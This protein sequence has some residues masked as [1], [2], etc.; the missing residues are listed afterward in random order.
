MTRC[1]F[2]RR[3]LV[4]K[5]LFA[6]Y[7]PDPDVTGFAPH[8]LVRSLERELCFL[9]IE[10]RW[11]PLGGGVT[12]GTAC[13]ACT[14]KLPA[15]GILVAV[16][17]Q[18]GRRFEIHILQV[19]LQVQRPVT[20]GALDGTM[21]ASELEFRSRVIELAKV[22]ESSCRVAGLTSRSV[23]VYEHTH[24]GRE[25]VAVRI[26]VTS[27]ARQA[28]E[29][30]AARGGA[31]T[32]ERLMTI[33]AIGCNMRAGENKPGLL[34]TR[35]RERSHVEIVFAMALLAVV[36][37]WRSRELLLVRVLVAVGTLREFDFEYCR[38]ARWSVT[39]GAFDVRVFSAKRKSSLR[40]VFDGE[41]GLLETID[42]VTAF[43]LAAVLP[44]GK[45]PVVRVRLVA[46]CALLMS[47]VSLEIAPAV[48]GIA[49]N[50]EVPS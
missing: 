6:I 14:R 36:K 11:L 31:D 2:G 25:F 12:I 34:V 28:L 15:V 26:D 8:I 16:L 24:A 29:V 20:S 3:W 21:S 40:M 46:I 37:I 18:L 17:A 50:V 22:R 5:D 49:I 27:S 30:V 35:K 23:A 4:K 41:D 19:A 10:E 38:P 47:D 48:A 1:T 9:V 44:L 43:A 45:L 42:P 32:I 33:Q 13:L 39:L 7:G